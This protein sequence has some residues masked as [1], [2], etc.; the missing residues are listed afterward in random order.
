MP[1]PGTQTRRVKRTCP[2]WGASH[3]PGSWI[4]RV[5]LVPFD[6]GRDDIGTQLALLNERRQYCHSN[7]CGISLEVRSQRISRV[8]SSVAVDSKGCE[9][10]AHERSDLIWDRL[11]VV[12]HR[13]DRP[14]AESRSRVASGMRWSEPHQDFQSGRRYRRYTL[15]PVQELARRRGSPSPHGPMPSVPARCVNATHERTQQAPNL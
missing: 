8:A 2:N 10:L 3:G 6:R 11:H 15:L 9:R 14:M 7:V 13:N 5:N 1:P 12:R 4:L